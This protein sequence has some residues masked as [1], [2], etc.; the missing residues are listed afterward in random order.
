MAST[1][2]INT[3]T[4]VTTAGS[5][6][7]TGEGNSTTTNLQ[8][9]L[10]K[11]WFNNS[12]GSSPRDSLNVSSITDNQTGDDSYA[13]TNNMANDDYASITAG[14]RDHDAYHACAENLISTSANRCRSFTRGGNTLV[15]SGYKAV[16]V[17]GDL[18]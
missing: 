13:M 4:G 16:A 17:H 10:A 2:K 3:L 18:A 12:A 11:Q 5:I 1:L 15:D 6:A 9:G 8:Q 14:W 7:V